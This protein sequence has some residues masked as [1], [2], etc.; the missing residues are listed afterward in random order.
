M[1]EIEG[2]NRM[3]MHVLHIPAGK[4]HSDQRQL[5]QVSVWPADK[6]TLVEKLAMQAFLASV[7]KLRLASK[8]YQG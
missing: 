5:V 6:P 8:P 4:I 3:V 7:K 2:E 1:S